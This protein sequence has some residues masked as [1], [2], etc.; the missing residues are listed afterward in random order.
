[1]I[2]VIASLALGLLL[3]GCAGPNTP[4]SIYGGECRIFSDP[5]FRVRGLTTRDNRWIATTQETGIQ[6]CRWQRPPNMPE[7]PPVVT[8]LEVDCATV[9]QAVSMFGGDMARAES[10][11]VSQGASP[12]Q[13]AAARTCLPT[14][15]KPGL[16]SRH[17]MTR[18]QQDRFLRAEPVATPAVVPLPTA[19][20]AR[21]VSPAV[22]EPAVAAPAPKKSRWQR[23]KSKVKG[24]FRRRDR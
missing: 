16:G 14:T 21:D 1:M 20:P 3:V 18:K 15:A 5:G 10:Y 22:A 7:P 9:R 13:I 4:A 17:R 6:V 24:W 12:E 23:T 2:K 11:A 8:G 19:A